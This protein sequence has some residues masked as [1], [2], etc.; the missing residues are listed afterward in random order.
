MKTALISVLTATLLGFASLASGRLFDAADFIS[1]VFAT[2]LVAWTVEQYSREPRVLT[3]ARPIRFPVKVHGASVN[4]H[5][6][7]A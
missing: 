7:A 6:L 3:L 2:G 1:I 4:T 5:R